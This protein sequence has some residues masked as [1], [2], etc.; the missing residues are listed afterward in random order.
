VQALNNSGTIAGYY[1]DAERVWH[2]FIRNS[3]GNVTVFDDGNG[4]HS[5]G[6]GTFP[7]SINAN[8]E[9]AGYFIGPDDQEHGFLRH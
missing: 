4:G 1:S 7:T 3:Q 2:G 5:I 9:V 6:Q 8:G